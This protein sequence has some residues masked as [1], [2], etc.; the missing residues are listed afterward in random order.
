[1]AKSRRHINRR[2]KIKAKMQ[3]EYSEPVKVFVGS[4]TTNSGQEKNRYRKNPNATA[5]RMIKRY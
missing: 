4:Y 5:I 2:A 3:I 1:M